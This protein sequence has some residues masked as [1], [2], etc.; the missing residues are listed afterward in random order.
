LVVKSQSPD[1]QHYIHQPTT[2]EQLSGEG[3]ASM[4]ELQQS[5]ESVPDVQ[6]VVSDGLN[7]NAIMDEGHL[8]PYLKKLTELLVVEN[9]SV[10]DKIIVVI[11]GRVRIGYQIG[12][13]LFNKVSPDQHKTIIH[14]IGERPGTVHHNYSVYIASPSSKIWIDNKMDHNLAR[15]ISG[16]SDTAAKPEVAAAQTIDLVK[17]LNRINN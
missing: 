7:A 17:E 11:N 10:S 12:H 9:M 15:V 8:H 16:I 13:L 2:G 6:I 3:V 14:V 1:R 5:W 4:A